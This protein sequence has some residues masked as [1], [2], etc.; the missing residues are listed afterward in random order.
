M[1]PYGEEPVEI[2]KNDQVFYQ[3][4]DLMTQVWPDSGVDMRQGS[5]GPGLK[6]NDGGKDG[7]ANKENQGE[8]DTIEGKGDKMSKVD[9][10]SLERDL[11]EYG[12]NE[13]EDGG[14]N[15]MPMLM[16]PSSFM[17]PTNEPP[18]SLSPVES[19][20]PIEAHQ[21]RGAPKLLCES[22]RRRRMDESLRVAFLSTLTEEEWER[23]QSELERKTGE[24]WTRVAFMECTWAVIRRY[25]TQSVMRVGLSQAIMRELIEKTT[26]STESDGLTESV[27]EKNAEESPIM[28]D[29]P[30]RKTKKGL[31][32]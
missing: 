23:Y 11:L 1:A 29:Q 14:T 26:E 6:P 12:F 20:S 18:A 27:T 24:T 8:D 30:I 2:V 28:R 7:D 13:T 17:S 19:R 32:K 22:P 5:S 3:A 4:G 9:L 15:E 25:G 21:G 10:A 16:A 31:R